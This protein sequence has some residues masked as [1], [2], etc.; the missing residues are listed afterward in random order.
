MGNKFNKEALGS[1]RKARRR[2]IE[3]SRVL[4]PDDIAAHLRL[5]EET[6]RQ[7]LVENPPEKQPC[8]VIDSASGAAHFFNSW[9]MAY[10]Y[11]C[12]HGLAHWSWHTRAAYDEWVRVNTPPALPA[13]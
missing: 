8:V 2:V 4:H 12:Q 11:I 13:P 6:V 7:I 1:Y 10:R 3:A 9:R 5:D